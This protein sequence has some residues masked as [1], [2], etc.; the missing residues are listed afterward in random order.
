M[1]DEEQPRAA[2]DIPE[3]EIEEMIR[4]VIEQ[5]MRRDIADRAL[6]WAR[7]AHRRPQTAT[8]HAAVN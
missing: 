5:T 6:A 2:A 7:P 8:R 4:D 1:A 3:W